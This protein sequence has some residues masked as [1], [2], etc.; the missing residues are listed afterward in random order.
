[1]RSLLIGCLFIAS[2]AC[3]QE[4]FPAIT[5]GEKQ[6]IQSKILGE[7]RELY[8][9]TPDRIHPKLPLILVFDGESLFGPT[10]A[11]VKFMNYSSEIPQIPEAIVVGIPNTDR[12][13]DMPIPQ[14]YGEN[15]GENNFMK[16][17][18]EELLPYLNKKYPLN[19]HTISIGHSQ[20]G[21]FVSYLLSKSPAKFPWAI[22]LD[23][24][25]TVDPQINYVKDAFVKSMHEEKNKTRYASVETLYGWE[26]EF[27][28]TDHTKQ[29][30]LPDET[31]E[32]MPF[33]GI[34]DGLAFLF[35]DFR[36][37][38][39]DMK[40]AELQLHYRSLSEK[41]GYTYEI[42]FRVLTASASR[43]MMESRKI[44]IMDLVN[45]A[46]TKYTATE[47]TAKLK[48]DA[49]KITKDPSPLLDSFLSLPKPAAEKIKP[50]IGR[51]VGQL[52]VRAGQAMPLDIEISVVNG[53][54]KFESVLPWAPTKKEEAA[55]FSVSDKGELIFGRRNRGSGLVIST[56]KIDAKGHLVG[57]E[58]LI[59]FTIP[60]DMPADI[61]ERMD[62]IIKNPN[63]F[64]LIK[65]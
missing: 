16:F 25:M 22:A 20:G 27:Q 54:T 32:S 10:V 44:E 14:Q 24:P 12:D 31:H 4:K 51:W 52:M 61:K 42:P 2:Q 56:A 26:K 30:T 57:E 29:I 45:Y 5:L 38:R 33:K 43:K 23:A 19:G 35:H 3:A 40:L 9:Y 46:E 8:V 53:I 48:T 41:Y 59:G 63:T 60:D 15:K 34:Y 21:L 62:F 13:S 65:K 28:Q 36:P 58:W 37:E 7:S 50:Y 11:A 17:I 49:A 6:T 55:I 64:D 39:K 18:L 47:R 1:M